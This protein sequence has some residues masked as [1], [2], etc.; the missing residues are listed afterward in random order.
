[1]Y[2]VEGNAD[3]C[4][5]QYRTHLN[6]IMHAV[7]QK[8]AVQGFKHVLLQFSVLNCIGLYYGSTLLFHLM[9]GSEVVN[10]P[11][12]HFC[13]EVFTHKLH[14][15]Q[16]VLKAGGVFGQPTH[17]KHTLSLKCMTCML[18]DKQYTCALIPFDESLSHPEAHAFENRHTDRSILKRRHSYFLTVHEHAR[19]SCKM[20]VGTCQ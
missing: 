4:S 14:Y 16:L 17:S 1:M 7:S 8:I 6:H 13:P 15:I 12:E 20:I 9:I 11:P 2:P 10:L 19:V 3:R 18:L 5:S